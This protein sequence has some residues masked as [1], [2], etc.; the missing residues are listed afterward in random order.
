MLPLACA[1][2][3]ARSASRLRSSDASSCVA[4]WSFAAEASATDVAFFSRE[5]DWLR[6]TSA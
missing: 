6:V 3:L 1:V 5:M 4:S 2:S